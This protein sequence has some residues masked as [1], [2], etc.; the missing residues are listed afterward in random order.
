M[1]LKGSGKGDEPSRNQA[2]SVFKFPLICL[3]YGGLIR[4]KREDGG[5][6]GW[7]KEGICRTL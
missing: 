5:G 6:R 2:T 1:T 3:E 4:E 7:R